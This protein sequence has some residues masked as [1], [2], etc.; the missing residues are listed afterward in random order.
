MYTHITNSVFELLF[1]LVRDIFLKCD[2]RI[3]T[4]LHVLIC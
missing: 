4:V 2:L 3:T 1:S